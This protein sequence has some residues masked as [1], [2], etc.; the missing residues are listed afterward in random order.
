MCIGLGS[1]DLGPMARQNMVDGLCGRGLS[2]YVMANGK[3]SKTKEEAG[4]GQ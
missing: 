1:L 3:Q 4:A 2:T